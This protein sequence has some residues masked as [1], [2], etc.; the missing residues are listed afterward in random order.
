MAIVHVFF[1]K[2]FDIFQATWNTSTPG[3]PSQALSAADTV[4]GVEAWKLQIILTC[5]SRSLRLVDGAC[6]SEFIQDA[7]DF[8]QLSGSVV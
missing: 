7:S 4:P 5:F 3:K 2:D 6:S 8:G 1:S